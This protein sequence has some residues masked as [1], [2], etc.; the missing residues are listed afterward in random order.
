LN[1]HRVLRHRVHLLGG[2]VLVV[3]ALLLAAPAAQAQGLPTDADLSIDKTDDPDPVAVGEELT[4]TLTAENHGLLSTGA[5]IVDQLP[6]GNA[7]S[8]NDYLVTFQDASAGC[9]YNGATHDVTCRTSLLELLLPGQT[10]T[11]RIDVTPTLNAAGK[12]I[13]DKA[14]I[15]GNEPDPTPPNNNEDTEFT[16]V[17]PVDENGNGNG[18]TDDECDGERAGDFEQTEGDDVITGTEGDDV[19]AGLG[20]DDTI[21]GLGG[22]DRLCGHAG[23]DNVSGDAGVDFVLGGLDDDDLTGDADSDLVRGGADDDN[24]SGNAARDA[25]VGDSGN[26]DMFGNEENDF[27]FGAAGDDFA[28]GGSGTRDWCRAESEV[29]C[30]R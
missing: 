20:G 29:R 10:K 18:E 1:S 9:A 22:N 13:E 7:A 4:Y 27:L 6:G 23:E 14:R 5:E 8:G 15:T 28:D 2:A 25:I 30:E 26:D 24:A 19:I 12:T 21:N 11:F 17:L 3:L 16:A